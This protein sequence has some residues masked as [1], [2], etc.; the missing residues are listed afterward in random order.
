MISP[1]P[2]YRRLSARLASIARQ[3][4]G[5]G[6]LLAALVGSPATLAGTASGAFI[7]QS[8]DFS[9]TIQPSHAAAFPV[10]EQYDA[11]KRVVEVILS[12]APL[13]TAAVVAA[14]QPHTQAI[15][16]EAL[17]GHDY[18]LL[19]LAPDGG[20]SMNATFGQTMTQF[21][22]RAGGSLQAE[23]AVNT[24]ER[25]AG[26]LYTT[27]PMRLGSDGVYTVDLQ[28]DTQVT[29]PA[30]ATTLPKGGGAPGKALFKFLAAVKKQQWP[31]IQAGASPAA[32]R[33]FAADYR[34]DRENAEHARD[35]V[36]MWLPRSRLQI[37]GGEQRGEVADLEVEG[38]MHP[39]MRAVY[40][41][42]MRLDGKTWRFEGAAVLGL[43]P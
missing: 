27:L 21:L 25:V 18:V 9:G 40:L 24:A 39:G 2:G 32:L 42:R 16:Q 26:R 38:E 36:Q 20:V 23:L 6:L 28:F 4:L 1:W 41:A 34:N 11:R 22:D 13:D 43:L 19:W 31:A 10:R 12:G 37:T 30:P 35:L 29:R 7:V 15:N 14:L 8:P 3:A 33:L 5:L 17:M